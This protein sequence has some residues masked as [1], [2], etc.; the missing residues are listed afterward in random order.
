M[1]M[2]YYI[3]MNKIYGMCF[4]RDWGSSSNA[5]VQ[6]EEIGEGATEMP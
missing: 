3:R 2:R 5:K 1:H 6:R 4:F